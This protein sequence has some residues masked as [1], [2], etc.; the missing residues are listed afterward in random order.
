MTDPSF[1]GYGLRIGEINT[2]VS[3]LRDLGL[4]TVLN[5]PLIAVIGNQSAGKIGRH[6]SC[7]VH[8]LMSVRKVF[9]GGGYLWSETA[10]HR[11][12]D[13]HLQVLDH[14]PEI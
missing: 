1:G 11:V 6:Q 2:V 14:T 9:A 3:K 10:D 8:G 13:S 5:I 12:L 4:Q 7:R